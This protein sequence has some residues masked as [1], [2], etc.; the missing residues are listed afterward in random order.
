MIRLSGGGGG[1]GSAPVAVVTTLKGTGAGTYTTT[2]ASFV[3]VDAVNLAISLTTSVK[4]AILLWASGCLQNG[5]TGDYS[6]VAI[7][8]DGTVVSQ[9]AMGAGGAVALLNPWSVIYSEPGDGSAHTWA[10]YFAVYTGTAE[11]QNTVNQLI[12]YTTILQVPTA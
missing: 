6:K 9:V 5:T 10:L 8:K 3:A 11:I 2:S 4:Q 12:P 1:G 7:A